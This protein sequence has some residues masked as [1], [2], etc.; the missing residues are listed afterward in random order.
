MTELDVKIVL[1][2][3]HSEL[4]A[5]DQFECIIGDCRGLVINNYLFI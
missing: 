5:I 3:F 2:A 4:L 1:D